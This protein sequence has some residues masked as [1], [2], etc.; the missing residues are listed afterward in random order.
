AVEQRR[1]WGRWGRF[2]RFGRFE[3]LGVVHRDRGRRGVRRARAERLVDSLRRFAERE[4]YA[5]GSQDGGDPLHS[6]LSLERERDE[7]G[8]LEVP[9]Q[10]DVAHRRVATRR[11][12]GVPGCQRRILGY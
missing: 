8:Q 9:V 4:H 1:R 6:A 10:L 7:A 11:E 2:G 5:R 12:Y 3:W